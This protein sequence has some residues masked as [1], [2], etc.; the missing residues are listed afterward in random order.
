[1]SVIECE[2][3]MPILMK[4]EKL[5]AAMIQL[6][7]NNVCSYW[8]ENGGPDLFAIRLFYKN[9]DNLDPTANVSFPQVLSQEG[10]V[11]LEKF[12]PDPPGA[13]KRAATLLVMARLRHLF[14]L[15]TP[16]STSAN[17][18]RIDPERA[19]AWA[20][21]PCFLL[22]AEIIKVLRVYNKTAN[23]N[24]GLDNWEGFPSVHSE[25]EFV[26]FV[27]WL[28]DRPS[29]ELH[30]PSAQPCKTCDINEERRGR[31]ILATSLILEAVHYQNGSTRDAMVGCC[32]EALMGLKEEDRKIAFFDALLYEFKQKK[33]STKTQE[34]K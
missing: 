2:G 28:C 9:K 33:P 29:E 10:S 26:H 18:K 24:F 22:L 27:N 1:M 11:L 23:K 5:D 25:A 15:A 12:F 21:C 17:V 7:A 16:D 30:K 20:A 8:N 4:T 3:I 34:S 14:T 6:M 31:M 32:D 13:F 19:Y